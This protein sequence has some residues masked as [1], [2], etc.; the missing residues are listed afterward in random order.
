MKLEAWRVERVFTLRNNNSTKLD[1][2]GQSIEHLT[3]QKNHT[4]IERLQLY[5]S[6]IQRNYPKVL[7]LYTPIQ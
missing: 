1:F 7:E 4:R 3:F 5:I 6:T 2:K